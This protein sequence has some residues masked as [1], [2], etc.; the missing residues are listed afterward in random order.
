M[1]DTPSLETTKEKKK[2]SIS[3]STPVNSKSKSTLSANPK[4]QNSSAK[5]T[6]KRKSWRTECAK[7]KAPKS[8]TSKSNQPAESSAELDP[9][10]KKASSNS[11][12]RPS[13]R[14][15]SNTTS[16]KKLK[17]NE[18][19]EN[20]WKPERKRMIFYCHFIKLKFFL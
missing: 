14:T 19:A 12:A 3:I 16:G 9:S 4:D 7:E 2:S 18:P 11:A 17:R 6:N 15:K 10:K 20:R 5:C 8:T 1:P 13:V